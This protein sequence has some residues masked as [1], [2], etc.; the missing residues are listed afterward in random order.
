M[1]RFK[2][3]TDI[4]KS[5]RRTVIAIM[6]VGTFCLLLHLEKFE[7][8]NYIRDIVMIIVGALWAEKKNKG[9]SNVDKG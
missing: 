8:V 3:V 6:L 2:E 5:L 1:N 9:G 7:A 4:I